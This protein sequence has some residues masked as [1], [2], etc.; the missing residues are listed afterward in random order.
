MVLGFVATVWASLRSNTAI[1]GV[2]IGLD[3]PGRYFVLALGVVVIGFGIPFG[4]ISVGL[5]RSRTEG[6]R[7]PVEKININGDVSV[8]S[9]H[10]M[11]STGCREKLHPRSQDHGLACSGK[12]WS[13]GGRVQPFPRSR[14][15][16]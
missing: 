4:L 8:P 3:S 10:L 11:L 13:T 9:R 2:D 5:F 14:I 1:R 16:R 12:P 6:Q 15:D 7:L